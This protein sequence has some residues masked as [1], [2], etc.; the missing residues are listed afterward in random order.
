MLRGGQ[1]GD[2]A[3]RKLRAQSLLQGLRWQ[4]A[5]GV[6]ERLDTLHGRDVA[7]TPAHMPARGWTTGGTQL[8]QRRGVS[9]ERLAP[10]EPPPHLVEAEADRLPADAFELA[11]TALSGADRPRMWAGGDGAERVR[12]G[13]CSKKSL[14]GLDLGTAADDR[15]ALPATTQGN[16]YVS[17]VDG[18]G[19]AVWRWSEGGGWRCVH[20]RLACMDTPE[21]GAGLAGTLP[22]MWLQH[23]LLACADSLRLSR[24]WG[25]IPNFRTG[26][27][28]G[29]PRLLGEVSMGHTQRWGPGVVV[30]IDE[31]QVS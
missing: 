30:G 26:A 25:W 13:P 23:V 3:H 4:L 31:L 16:C 5:P 2:K 17:A 29:K 27:G 9:L 11:T 14:T 21:G 8:M 12:R 24:M 19:L 18:D 6:V 28:F 15:A 7:E 1:R 20:V 22:G 10:T